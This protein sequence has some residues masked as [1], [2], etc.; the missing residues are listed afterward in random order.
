AI[1]HDVFSAVWIVLQKRNGADAIDASRKADD[2]WSTLGIPHKSRTQLVPAA[3]GAVSWYASII[4]T[5]EVDFIGRA[6]AKTLSNRGSAIFGEC[7]WIKHAVRNFVIFL[8]RFDTHADLFGIDLDT[9]IGLARLH[10]VRVTG[11]VLVC[12]RTTL[13]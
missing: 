4:G 1:G 11:D 6:P 9:N 7:G 2:H 10:A 13:V 12:Q 3:H 8:P 5:P